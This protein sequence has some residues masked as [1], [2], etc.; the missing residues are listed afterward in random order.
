MVYVYDLPAL[1]YYSVPLEDF[2]N[3]RADAVFG[4]RC[5]G[6]M[7]D[8][9]TVQHNT[10]LIILWR[11]LRDTRCVTRTRNPEAADLFL[12]PTFPAR[13]GVGSWKADV[14][15]KHGE[16]G[17]VV[18]DL[19]RHLPFLN[20]RTAHRHVFILNKGHPADACRWWVQHHGRAGGVDL[21]TRAIHFA[22]SPAYRGSAHGPSPFDDDALADRLAVDPAAPWDATVGYPHL[23]SMP[24]TA[25]IHARRGNRPWAAFPKRAGL[26]VYLGRSHAWKWD[27]ANVAKQTR[28][29]V[30]AE[31]SNA[32]DATCAVHDPSGGEMHHAC[33]YAAVY[34]SATFCFQP[35]GDSPYRKGFYD[36]MLAGC[37]P[38]I[39]GVH[40]ERVA[41]WFV[42]KGVA[43]R[44]SESKYLNGTFRALD[45]LRAMAPADVARRQA[46]LHAHGHRLQYA[47]DDTAR[48][49]AVETLFVGALGLAHDLEV[50]Y[51]S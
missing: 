31:C 45:V 44:L 8:Y 17:G 30:F 35:P 1:W 41:P 50:L 5:K 10:A 26:A 51:A 47:V 48:G 4:P 9:G 19:D 22:Y 20:N 25:G 33:G 38:V 36:A 2:H 29:R 34:R 18:G 32:D 15:G 11:V 43:V 27:D 46:L 16:C 49:D 37:I 3:A 24:Y 6:S 39:F 12:A 21:L 7:D 40:N 28:D 23:V 14:T 13:K 42:P